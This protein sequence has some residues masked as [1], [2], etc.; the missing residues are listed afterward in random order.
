MTCEKCKTLLCLTSPR[1]CFKTFQV[2]KI[3]KER[4]NELSDDKVVSFTTNEC[5]SLVESL[6]SFLK[7][8]NSI[9]VVKRLK[10]VVRKFLGLIVTFV[11][12]TGEKVRMQSY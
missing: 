5:G 6:Q 12:V 7:S 1:N 3:S 9:C 11:E 8:S 4:V 2:K 10:L